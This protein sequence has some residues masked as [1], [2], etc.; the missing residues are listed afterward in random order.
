MVGYNQHFVPSPC[1]NA[2]TQSPYRLAMYCGECILLWLSC[3]VN[4]MIIKV[5]IRAILEN[6][7]A[8]YMKK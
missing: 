6:M 5:L 7:G 8:N 2:S 3:V 4:I 1:D